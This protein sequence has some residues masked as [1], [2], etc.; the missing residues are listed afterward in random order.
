MGL[1]EEL[2]KTFY[3]TYVV[4]CARC[5]IPLAVRADDGYGV[6]DI[7][8]VSCAFSMAYPCKQQAAEQEQGGELY[9]D[10]LSPAER[11][12]LAMGQVFRSSGAGG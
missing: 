11:E 5:D 3:N 12:T 9:Q 6:V 1:I 10:M 2:H 7:Y 4:K 8:C